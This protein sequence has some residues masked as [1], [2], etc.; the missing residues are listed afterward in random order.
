MS[1]VNELESKRLFLQSLNG[2]THLERA[3]A[4]LWYESQSNDTYEMTSSELA[5]GLHECGFPKPHV[6]KLQKTLSRS[7]TVT[8]GKRS[9]TFRV[10]A[11]RR[12]ALEE[13]LSPHLKVRKTRVSDAILSVDVFSGTRRPYLVALST[14][15]NGTYDHGWYDACAVLCR[16]IVE[17]LL[18]E[19][20]IK[21][22]ARNEIESNGALV[23]LDKV[24]SAAKS[25][26]A[27][28]LGRNSPKAL[29]SVKS[30]GDTAAHDRTHLT[31]RQDIDD[32]K[33]KF[34]V[35]VSELLSLAG[36]SSV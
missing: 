2:R 8:K 13:I 4:L 21:A 24:I 16:R 1:K 31:Q 28:K 32:M 11:A 6:T 14:Q 35:L 23:M 36:I 7:R 22:N 19:C 15:I 29:D 18:I 17:S 3:I 25:T 20:F 9:G 27:F 5:V 12:T 26:N 33:A 10:N 34:R 30:L